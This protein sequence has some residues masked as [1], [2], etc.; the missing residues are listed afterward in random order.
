VGS[1]KNAPLQENQD[2]LRFVLC[3][4]ICFA[5][6]AI[7]GSLVIAGIQ[8]MRVKPL[9]SLG[10]FLGG[11][12]SLAYGAVCAVLFGTGALPAVLG[13]CSGFLIAAGFLGC[14]PIVRKGELVKCVGDGTRAVI[15]KRV[16]RIG[17]HAFGGKIRLRSVKI[18]GS[19]KKIGYGAF[20][21]CFFL[22]SAAIPSGVEE[23]ADE[24]FK[25]CVRLTSVTIP[26]SVVRIGKRAFED[27]GSLESLILPDSVAEILPHAFDGCPKLTIICGEGSRAHRYCLENDILFIFDYQFEAYHGLLPPGYEKLASPFLAD[28]EKPYIFVSYSHRDRDAILPILK[29]LYEDG[30]RIWYDEGLT[31]GDKY[32]ET[33]EARVRECAVF[34]LFDSGNSAR[35]R[36]CREKEIPWAAEASRPVIRCLLERTKHIE[37]DERAAAATVF[38]EGIAGA[39]ETIGGTA[40]GAPREAKGIT[41]VVNP[42][43]R[44]EAGGDEAGGDGFAYCLYSA[45]R[46]AAARAI[47]LEAR[48]GGCTLYDEAEQGEDGE[49]RKGCACLVALLDKAFLADARLMAVL[50]EEFRNGRDI[51]VC[52]LEQIGEED[53]PPALAGLRRMQWLNFAF[54]INADMSAKLARHLQKRGCRNTAVLPGFRYEKTGRGIVIVRYTGTDPNPRIEGEY[55]GTPVTEIAENCFV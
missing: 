52:Q 15:P 5:F 7:G 4:F 28:E 1:V 36:Y 33:L 25:D 44:D 40:K 31:I 12:A 38:P 35:S 3:L 6:A 43:A 34:L 24:T 10:I 20:R 49:K 47:L 50:E 2:M 39:L 51:A 22:E 55:G 9:K 48:N 13:A 11:A 18:P 37:M 27:C 41:V 14:W 45:G 26:D 42:A 17:A 30:W 23:I 19:V 53:I 8:N 16:D 21:K 32:D 54:G 46:P 29:T